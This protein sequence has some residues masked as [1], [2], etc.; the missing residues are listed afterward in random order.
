[1]NFKIDQMIFPKSFF[2][3][4][5]SCIST[6]F[7]IEISILRHIEKH[8]GPST[9][10]KLLVRQKHLA[11]VYT[12]LTATRCFAIIDQPVTCLLYD[13]ECKFR[14]LD[15]LDIQLILEFKISFGK[16]HP[17]FP[18]TPSKGFLGTRCTFWD[19]LYILGYA[20]CSTSCL[21]FFSTFGKIHQPLSDSLLVVPTG[22][23]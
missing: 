10:T 6:S 16:Y 20:L 9:F 17:V 12:P 4:Q 13:L 14:F 2:N 5:I 11:F 15:E 8:S 19:M 1:M 7:K 22:D 18:K 23:I 3:F 21:I